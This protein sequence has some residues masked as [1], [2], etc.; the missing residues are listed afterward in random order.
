MIFFSIFLRPYLKNI[1]RYQ[2]LYKIWSCF[3]LNAVFYTHLITFMNYL[4]HK[5][6]FNDNVSRN[7]RLIKPIKDRKVSVV[8]L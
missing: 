3:C 1:S 7:N 6:R 8:N 5:Y 2:V 4:I